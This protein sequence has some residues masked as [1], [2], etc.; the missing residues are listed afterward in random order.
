M[1]LVVLGSALVLLLYAWLVPAAAHIA[2]AADLPAAKV[3]TLA[4]PG[5]AAATTPLAPVNTTNLFLPW[6]AR[7]HVTG[8]TP[9]PGPSQVPTD[10]PTATPTDAPTPEPTSTSTDTPTPEP[11]ATPTDIPLLTIGPGTAD[12]VLIPAGDFQ[13]GCDATNPAETCAPSE[14]PLH[15]VTLSAYFIDK[16]EVTNARYRACM[17]A[18]GCT[19][20]ESVSSATRAPYFGEP[21]YADYPV[22]RVVWAQAD[23]FCRWEG[24]RLP[25]EA[26]WERAAR[27]NSDTRKYPWGDA[28]PDCTMLN[29]QGPAGSCTG[30]TSRVGSYPAGASPAGVMD[31]SGN[32]WEWVN[33]WYQLDYYGGSPAINPP[34]PDTGSYPTIADP[35]RV[36][37]GGSWLYTEYFVRAAYR[38]YDYLDIADINEGF[39]C[40]RT[41]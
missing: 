15:T 21:A 34:G 6:L 8:S 24:K 29:Y 25:S 17:G 19:A 27:G 31:M 38:D 1:Q 18:G 16:Y 22:I 3:T 10:T 33:D 14:Q 9:L 20:P 28:A 40:A 12:E 37:R 13:M 5:T 41:Q 35:G 4:E 30:D 26:E 23:A 39:R 11:T 2:M 36:L 7:V 32:V